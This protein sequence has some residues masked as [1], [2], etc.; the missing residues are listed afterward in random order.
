M[1]PMMVSTLRTSFVRYCPFHHDLL[2]VGGWQGGYLGARPAKGAIDSSCRILT[3][4]DHR[5]W[6]EWEWVLQ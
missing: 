5:V 2:E 3:R 1:N 4:A 6:A